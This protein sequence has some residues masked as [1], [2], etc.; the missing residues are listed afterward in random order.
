MPNAFSI[1]R[2]FEHAVSEYTG[3]PYCVAVNSC[4][5]AIFLAL[6]YQRMLLDHDTRTD[7]LDYL[8]SCPKFT[9][10]GVPMQIKLAG[11]NVT[12]R[13]D[14]W[15]G[16]YQFTPLPVFD[17]ARRFT[18][19][20]YNNKPIN[21][22]GFVCVSFHWSKILGIQQGGAILH[23]DAA[24]DKWFRKARF[25]G[26]TE[27]VSPRDDTFDQ[28]GWHMYMSPEI[29]AE[30]LVRMMHIKSQNADLPW[31]GYPDLSKV[32]LFK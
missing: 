8:V 15:N 13:D 3:A 31:D 32:E 25:D 10:I 2:D 7:S 29:A 21:G 23:S 17:A 12:F 22:D 6:T 5:N 1:V 9:Y 18:S 27:G 4:T 28:I 19:N 24:A 16:L 14:K 20:M 11:F 30:G 26:R